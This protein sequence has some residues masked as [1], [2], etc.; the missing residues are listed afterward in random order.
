MLIVG[1]TVPCAAESCYDNGI[2]YELNPNA[3][4]CSV[5]QSSSHYAGDVVIPERI[6]YQGEYYD[7]TAIGDN[8]FYECEDLSSVSIPNTVTTIGKYAFYA[9]TGLT[10]ITLPNSL[11]LID[12]GAFS[13][14]VALTSLIIPDSVSSINKKAFESCRRLSTVTIG[15]S[16]RNLDFWAFNECTNLKKLYFNA[17]DCTGDSRSPFTYVEEVIIG[18]GVKHINDCMFSQT[19]LTSVTIPNSVTTLGHHAFYGCHNLTSV[20]N[21][22]SVKIIGYNAFESCESLTELEIGNSVEEIESEAFKGCK[23]LTSLTIPNSVKII[24]SNTFE[25]CYKLTTVEMGNSVTEIGGYAFFFCNKLSEVRVKDLNTW[26]QINFVDKT[27]NPLYYAQDL[28]FGDSTKPLRNLVIEEGISVKRNAFYG[29]YI[30]KL[31]IKGA[32]SIGNYAF[33]SHPLTDICINASDLGKWSF[34]TYY[35][36]VSCKNIYVPCETPPSALDDTFTDYEGITLY[37]PSGKVSKYE[38]AL[39]CWW[40]FTN[41][42]ESDFADLDD[43]FAPD[44]ADDDSGIEEI[45]NDTIISSSTPQNN[46]IITLQGVIVKRNATNEDIKSLAPGLYIIRGEK[47][48][49]R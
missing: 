43:I 39:K 27:S 16:L 10:S 12:E 3:R 7:V 2:Y 32:K 33:Y 4:T 20:K 45:E 41:I 48:S 47:V 35:G 36:G 31:R 17:E 14:C 25:N 8:A 6:K 29:A 37:V 13:Y 1:F 11:T 38:N 9:C 19:N 15:K 24:G 49:V 34:N 23:S 42:Y 18:D 22:N 5:A 30:E 40:Q 26:L 46:D 44:D 28:Y 21:S